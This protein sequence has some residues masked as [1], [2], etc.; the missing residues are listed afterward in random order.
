MFPTFFPRSLSLS[1]CCLP[2]EW[3]PKTPVP[4][5]VLLPTRSLYL[6]LS[7]NRDARPLR[8]SPAITGVPSSAIGERRRVF[9]NPDLPGRQ[10]QFLHS[11]IQSLLQTL[12][13]SSSAPASAAATGFSD[14]QGHRAADPMAQRRTDRLR[15]LRTRLHGHESWLRRASCC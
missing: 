13:S 6:S 12:S 15:R 10:D 5:V 14:S 1:L 4:V 9:S 7:N 3:N 11:Q 2:T 8:I